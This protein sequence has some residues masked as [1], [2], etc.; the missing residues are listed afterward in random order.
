MAA[1][2]LGTYA[3]PAA[4]IERAFAGRGPCLI[5]APISAEEMVYP[6]VPPGAANSDMIGGK[7]DVHAIR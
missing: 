3:D 7:K 4:A 1:M 2:D 6:I 5:H